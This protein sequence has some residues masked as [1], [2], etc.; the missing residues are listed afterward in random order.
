MR[1]LI[2][3]AAILC[4]ALSA[5][6]ALADT[7]LT[8]SGNGEAYIAADTAVVSIGVS[9]RDKDALQAQG[10]ANETIA[11]VRQALTDGGVSPEDI[12]TGYINL[13]ATYDYTSADTEVI[14]AYNA[15]STLAV[16]VTDMALVGQVID[17]AFSAGAN[18]LDGVTFSASDESEAR[19]AAL[20]A[21]YADARTKAETLADA[22]GLKLSAIYSIQEGGVYSY[23]SGANNLTAKGF[24]T[25]G[26]ADRSTV[27]QA[28]KICVSASVTVTWSAEE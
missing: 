24:S 14:S 25:E 19:A 1:K 2:C 5:C 7:A 22:S 8:V 11:R 17:L 27:V 26:A 10:R 12:N 13:Y 6:S 15:S 16:K 9:V 18:T 23:D 28:A 4:L 21:A 3:I 20:K